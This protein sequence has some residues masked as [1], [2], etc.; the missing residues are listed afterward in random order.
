M[1]PHSTSRNLIFEANP[2]NKKR[3]DKKMLGCRGDWFTS[4]SSCVG[5]F[6]DIVRSEGMTQPWVR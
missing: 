3:N 2:T 4:R 6:L 1:E 5:A